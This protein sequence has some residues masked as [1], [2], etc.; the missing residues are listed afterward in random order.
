[1]E[2]KTD[3]KIPYKYQDKI[4]KVW[5]EYNV[6]WATTSKGYKSELFARDEDVHTFGSKTKDGLLIGLKAIVKRDYEECR[7]ERN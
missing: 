6:Y 5:Y 7:D 1:M 3:I 4:S 2:N